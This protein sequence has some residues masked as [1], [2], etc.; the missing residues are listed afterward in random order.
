MELKKHPVFTNYASDI[1][2]N[3]YSLKFNKVKQIIKVKHGRGYHQFSIQDR[4]SVV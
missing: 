2:G 3:I 1:D 4:K